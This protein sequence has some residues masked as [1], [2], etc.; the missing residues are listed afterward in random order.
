MRLDAKASWCR[1][2]PGDDY[3]GRD[4]LNKGDS[5]KCSG[6]IQRAKKPNE[7]GNYMVGSPAL[8]GVLWLAGFTRHFSPS[9]KNTNPQDP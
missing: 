2:N 1:K 6:S 8:R 7:L 4:R 9:V 3:C 5:P